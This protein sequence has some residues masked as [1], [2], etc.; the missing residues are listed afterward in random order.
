MGAELTSP[1]TWVKH[2]PILLRN[3]V[4]SQK[5]LSIYEDRR[6][7]STEDTEKTD[8]KGTASGQKGPWDQHR[9][10]GSCSPRPTCAEPAAGL[11]GESRVNGLL[12][13]Q[14]KPE[15]HCE[16]PG[17]LKSGRGIRTKWKTQGDHRCWLR[18]V[19]SWAIHDPDLDSHRPSWRGGLCERSGPSLYGGSHRIEQE[20]FSPKE[21]DLLGHFAEFPAATAPVPSQTH[22]Q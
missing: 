9:D 10:Q 20:D 3:K 4:N 1:C 18:R 7:K 16:R 12:P 11:L 15:Q 22:H 21:K 17:C 2:L 5:Q 14:T 13:C 6:P 19:E 8:G